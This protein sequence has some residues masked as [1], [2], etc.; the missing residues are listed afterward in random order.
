MVFIFTP[1]GV[2]YQTVRVLETLTV[3]QLTLLRSLAGMCLRLT[4]ERPDG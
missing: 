2:P 1:C 4:L 3:F